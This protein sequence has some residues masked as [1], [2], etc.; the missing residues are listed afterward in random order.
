MMNKL[1]CYNLEC[2]QSKTRIIPAPKN[3]VKEILLFIKDT[4]FQI[5]ILYET[6]FATKTMTIIILFTCYLLL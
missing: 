6:S 2:F 1:P 5:F 4:L 3:F